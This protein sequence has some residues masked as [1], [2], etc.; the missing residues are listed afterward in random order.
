MI[1]ADEFHLSATRPVRGRVWSALLVAGAAFLGQ[2][3]VSGGPMLRIV[4][5]LVA[6]L[7]L[8]IPAIEKPRSALIGLFVLLPFLGIVR[9]MFSSAFGA[10]ALDPLLLVSSAVALVIFMSLTL[11]H[12]MDFG[13]TPLAK[14]VFLLLLI[15]LV[16][17]VN[18]GQG[19]LLV[20]IV[21]IMINLIPIGFFFIARSVADAEMTHKVIRI[22]IV[23]GILAA[24]YGLFQVFFGFRGFERTWLGSQGYTALTVGGTTRPFSFF[25]NPAEYASYA[26]YALVGALALA[27]FGA[28]RKRALWFFWVAVIG[29]AG[30]LIGSRGFTV[31]IVAAAV[32]LLAAR[33]RNALL[34][35][36]IVVIL[37]SGIVLWSASTT[38]TSTIESKQAG[39]SQLIEQ[40]LRALRDP[41]DPAKSTLPIHWEQ[42]TTGIGYAITEQPFGLGTGVA[43]RGGAKFGGLQAGTELDIGDAFL[44]LGVVGGVLYILA[45]IV[46]VTEASRVRRALPGPVWI[47]IWTMAATSIGAW[48]NGGNYAVTPLIWFMIGAADGA[49]KR[50]RDRGLIDG[51]VN[52]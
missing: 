25:N 8:S 45:I 12:E 19:P 28:R 38:S 4:V 23:V 13:G 33:A 49:Y 21:G 14:I 17:V 16:Q 44:S 32:V 48:L 43:T 2:Q 36:G 5:A 41:F 35:T 42:A 26:H 52:A 37:I 18:P 50:M 22:V 10:A 46:A 1:T 47:G 3:I 9:H 40:Q 39:A 34:A 30:F 24:A 31:K 20:G 15:G 29:Y 27:L 51:A 7:A 11:N 6:A